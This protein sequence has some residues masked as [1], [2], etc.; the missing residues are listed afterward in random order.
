MARSHYTDGA[1]LCQARN[2]SFVDMVPIV[3]CLVALAEPF[4]ADSSV[5]QEDP[6]P[7]FSRGPEL[8]SPLASSSTPARWL[9]LLALDDRKLDA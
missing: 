6:Q 9:L 1:R 2:M 7:L 5:L 4:T 8:S 3:T